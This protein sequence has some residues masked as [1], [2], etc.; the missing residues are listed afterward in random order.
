MGRQPAFGVTAALF[1]S[2]LPAASSAR[3]ATDA[4]AGT[5]IEVSKPLFGAEPTTAPPAPSTFQLAT[6]VAP[7]QLA[8]TVVWPALVVA[9]SFG[10]AAGVPVHGARYARLVS[11]PRAT[12]PS[13]SS[14]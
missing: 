5:V 11:L 4:C 12:R 6:P 13:K 1:A 2:G 10:G 14:S 9:A 8:L 7:F 3:T